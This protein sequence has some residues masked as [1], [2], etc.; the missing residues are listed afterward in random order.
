MKQ[1]RVR[2]LSLIVKLFSVSRAV[3]AVISSSNLLNL[4]EVEVKK[5]DDTLA[6]LSILE[7]LFEVMT[8]VFVLWLGSA[9]LAHIH[10]CPSQF[11]DRMQ[12]TLNCA[13]NK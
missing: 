9:E 6:T 5:T 4:I 13:H 1:G 3:A 2:V 10:M 7:L 12:P 8:C 11:I